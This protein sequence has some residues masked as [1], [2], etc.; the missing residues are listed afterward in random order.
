MLVGCAEGGGFGVEF[1]GREAL[2]L[3]PSAGRLA[4]TNHFL[5]SDIDVDPDVE[6]SRARLE[7][8]D[9]AA[10]AAAARDWLGLARILSEQRE[11]HPICVPFREKPGWRT[12]RLGTVCAVVMDLPARRMHL[13]H[14]PDPHAPW[15]TLELA[16]TSSAVA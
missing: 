5:R 1:T 10:S 2:E 13:R 6:N 4:H 7:R 14:G 3:A 11:P 15:R 9:A 12:A 16:D 8:A